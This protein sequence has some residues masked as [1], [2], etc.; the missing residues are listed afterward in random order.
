MPGFDRTS[1]KEPKAATDLLFEFND[2]P[3]FRLERTCSHKKSFDLNNA[4]KTFTIKVVRMK[5]HFP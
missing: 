5:A 2:H 4:A 3:I 1:S